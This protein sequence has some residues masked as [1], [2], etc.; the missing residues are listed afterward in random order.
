[1]PYNQGKAN[2]VADALS[3]IIMGRTSHVEDVKKELVNDIHRLSRQGLR[4]VDS[5][6]G[7]VS[8]HPSS[9][10]S[11]VV[12][13]KEGQHLDPLLMELK[14]LVF[15]YMNAC[16]SFGDDVIIRF[17]DRLCVLDVDDL[18][19]MIIIEAKSSR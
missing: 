13:V 14:D 19:T 4:L 6:N 9:E 8:V 17:Q 10:S 1:M 12:E 3:R 15:V 2:V 5:T 16:F 18:Q 7:R 11:L